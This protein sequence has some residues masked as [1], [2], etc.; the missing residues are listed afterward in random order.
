LEKRRGW[1]EGDVRRKIKEK[2]CYRREKKER[3]REDCGRSK[4]KA[5]GEVRG[6]KGKGYI[7]ELKEKDIV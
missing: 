7:E 2:G 3:E 1:K 5:S 4:K 6:K